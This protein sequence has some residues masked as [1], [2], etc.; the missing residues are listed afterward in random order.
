ML[1]AL[2]DF[3]QVIK[4]AIMSKNYDVSKK[5]IVSNTA[6]IDHTTGET[7]NSYSEYLEGKNILTTDVTG[8]S[9]GQKFTNSKAQLIPVNKKI[10]IVT[11][12]VEVTS[13]I[14]SL[15]VAK[16]K[17]KADIKRRRQ[18][19]LLSIENSVELTPEN[20]SNYINDQLAY[21][22]L[23]KEGFINAAETGVLS[24]KGYNNNPK[25]SSIYFGNGTKGFNVVMDFAEKAG[26]D[27]Y[28]AVVPRANLKTAGLKHNASTTNSNTTKPVF[29]NDVVYLIGD[30]KNEKIYVKEH[31]EIDKINAKY[32]AELTALEQQDNEVKNESNTDGEATPANIE[33]VSET[34]N[35]IDSDPT[36]NEIDN[37][38]QELEPEKELDG[39]ETINTEDIDPNDEDL[40]FRKVESKF[41]ENPL[42]ILTDTEISWIIDTFGEEHLAP[43]AQAKFI[44]IKGEKAYGAYSNGM[45]FLARDGKKGTAYHEA[46]HLVLDLASTS[47]EKEVL[48][49]A[50]KK[51]FG[52]INKRSQKYQDLKTTY[53]NKNEA[54]LAE[55]YYEEEMAEAFRTFMESEESKGKIK[56]TKVGIAIQ[57]FFDRIRKAILAMR[58]KGSQMLNRDSVYLSNSIMN[59]AFLNI[60]NGNVTFSERAKSIMDKQ[61]FN[62]NDF[63][64]RRKKGFTE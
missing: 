56:K 23:S 22:S 10:Q 63:K 2:Q 31:T 57:K 39:T 44:L 36:Q 52:E 14:D 38:T 25:Y 21:R 34:D 29:T 26:G 60:K 8:L 13:D 6:T 18:V 5:N 48:M 59:K 30:Y 4:D 42:N 27:P 46:F 20:K 28:I 12:S 32:D 24:Q 41:E 17:T 15:D 58:I 45:V 9:T 35:V 19:E 1:E 61:Y 53:P 7:Y 47:K 51:V 64:L 40:V 54:E 43:M 50:A 33:I 11:P 3:R 49:K 55:V 16:A 37:N 62:P